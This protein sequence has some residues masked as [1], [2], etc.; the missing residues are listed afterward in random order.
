MIPGSTS[1]CA[2]GIALILERPAWFDM[3]KWPY[4]TDDWKAWHMI[5][6]RPAPTRQ[7]AAEQLIWEE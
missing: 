2:T 7:S 4:Q 6:Y 3:G 5:G 1:Q